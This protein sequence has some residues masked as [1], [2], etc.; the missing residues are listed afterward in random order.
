MHPTQEPPQ[1]NRQMLTAIKGE[2]DCNTKI[3]GDVNTPLTPKDRSYRQKINKEIQA[4]TDNY[5]THLTDTYDRILHFKAAKYIF[6][7]SAYG[8]FSMTDHILGHKSSR[9]KFKKWNNIKH[10]F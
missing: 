3:V 10:L 8:T 9:G 7:S 5:S 4:L 2:T 6:F 1:Y